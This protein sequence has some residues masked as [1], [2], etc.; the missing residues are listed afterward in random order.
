MCSYALTAD[1]DCFIISAMKRII[2]AILCIFS[3]TF[4]SCGGIFVSTLTVRN[5]SVPDNYSDIITDIMISSGTENSYKAV[6]S[7][8]LDPG[9]EQ[10][11]EIDSGDWCVKVKG[12]RE[13]LSGRKD[14]ID[15]DT[16][17]HPVEFRNADTVVFI[18]DG[19]GIRPET[20]Q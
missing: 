11:V 4:F 3:L 8:T 13:Y 19:T 9:K 12:R 14:D 7:G 20:V 15:S 5:E 18:F 1:G 17:K 2:Y 6:W 10:S 16:Y